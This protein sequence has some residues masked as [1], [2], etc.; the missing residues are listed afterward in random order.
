MR[1]LFAVRDAHRSPVLG[2]AGSASERAELRVDEP[3][4]P[5]LSVLR[6]PPARSAISP[7]EKDA[8]RPRLLQM[9]SE[10]SRVVRS[11]KGRSKSKRAVSN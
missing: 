10:P 6:F 3:G 1:L 5:P 2:S 7:E 9:V 4:F 11:L 8:I